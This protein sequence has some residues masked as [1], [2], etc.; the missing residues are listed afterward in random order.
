MIHGRLAAIVLMLALALMASTALA[1]EAEALAPALAASAAPAEPA[2]AAP[3][4]AAPSAP[5]AP[6]EAAKITA[7][8]TP[9]LPEWLQMGGPVMY[10]LYLCLGL[11]VVFAVERGV[12]LRRRHILPPEFVRNVRA[13]AAERPSDPHKIHTYC[14][15][16]PSP[17][18][19]II[20]AGLKR[21]Q[22]PL[23]EMEKAIEDAGTKE[24]RQLRRN[25]RVLSGVA[26]VAPLVGLLGTVIGLIRC[27]AEMSGGDPA[28]RTER[29]ATGLSQA[30]VTT[31]AGLVVAIPAA[32]LYLVLVARIEKLVAE[33]DDLAMEFV[34]AM[35]ETKD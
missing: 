30:L 14:L 20:Q 19:R 12:R 33:L 17:V 18:A 21:L 10:A 2:E 31:A 13:L 23:P 3:A 24:V 32:V 22:R 27:F 1:A 9:T 25:C 26:Y 15:A 35:A 34:D 5:V 28:S 11:T 8:R 29:L 16:H 4:A 7:A 6:A